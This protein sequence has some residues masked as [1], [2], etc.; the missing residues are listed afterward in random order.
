MKRERMGGKDYSRKLLE[1][2]FLGTNLYTT[3]YT[4]NYG[5]LRAVPEV[6][7]RPV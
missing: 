7:P 5:C 6:G 4:F 3:I 1:K 2:K